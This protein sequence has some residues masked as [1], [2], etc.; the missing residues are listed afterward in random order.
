MV[1]RWDI[2]IQELDN[3]VRFIPGTKN[4]IADSLSRLCPNFAITTNAQ[5]VAALVDR[6]TVTFH[7]SQYSTFESEVDLIFSVRR[8]AYPLYVDVKLVF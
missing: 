4:E 6:G 5:M 2:A 7:F 1:I 8:G 3:T